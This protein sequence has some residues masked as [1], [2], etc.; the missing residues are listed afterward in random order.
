MNIHKTQK[1]II[2]ACI[3]TLCSVYTYAPVSYAETNT[4]VEEEVSVL[5]VL[6]IGSKGDR[7]VKLHE[8]LNRCPETALPKKHSKNTFT[9]T[10]A[11]KVR[12][13]QKYAKIAPNGKLDSE[14][15]KVIDTKPY[16]ERA[17]IES[18][19]LD[20]NE[21]PYAKFN[22]PTLLS[23]FIIEK[24]DETP[25]KIK[26]FRIGFDVGSTKNIDRTAIFKNI[27]NLQ[28]RENLTIK[29]T[30]TQSQDSETFSNESKPIQ[31]FDLYGT[32]KEPFKQNE[33]I[34]TS[35][36][37]SL[38]PF[39][40]E[41]TLTELTSQN[42]PL[43]SKK[44]KI[45]GSKREFKTYRTNQKDVAVENQEYIRFFSFL[46]GSQTTPNQQPTGNTTTNTPTGNTSTT[47]PRT[48]LVNQSNPTT[49]T[50]AT[51][52]S[53]TRGT[54]TPPPVNQP[55]PADTTTRNTNDPQTTPTSNPATCTERNL[56]TGQIQTVPCGTQPSGST[57]CYNTWVQGVSGQ[58]MRIVVAC[59]NTG[60][61]TGSTGGSTGS[62]DQPPVCIPI[63]SSSG[64]TTCVID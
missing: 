25:L 1:F 41:Y 6:T 26:K 38:T 12:T 27:T 62:G 31:I 2:S 45:V 37:I 18:K 30:L 17:S 13:L 56:T 14:T 16:C 63:T 19:P 32:I 53:P 52:Q 5:P 9:K 28:F 3:F 4:E 50:P 29:D 8:Y 15:E 23:R 58:T 60:G 55:R 11:Q 49:N 20:T 24:E 46:S 47:P 59:P 42:T 64:Q 33:C 39:I 51:N 40:Q 10:T 36:I 54:Q 7:I 57:V 35:C 44:D 34:D 21:V 48:P 22:Q 43:V 61:S